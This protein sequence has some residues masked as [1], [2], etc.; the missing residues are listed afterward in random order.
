MY[1]GCTLQQL[2]KME[3]LVNDSIY[4]VYRNWSEFVPL[5]LM[6]ANGNCKVNIYQIFLKYLTRP[7]ALHL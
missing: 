6:R 3:L 1:G 7:T 5:K 2:G 4:A